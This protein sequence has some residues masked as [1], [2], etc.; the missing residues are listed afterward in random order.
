MI[1]I[2]AAGGE[3]VQRT[4]R[5]AMRDGIGGMKVREMLPEEGLGLR[6]ENC[7]IFHVLYDV[8]IVWI[9]F[10]TPQSGKVR[11]AIRRARRRRFEV[12]LAV[13]SARNAGC[14]L[15][16][17]LAAQRKGE[18]PNGGRDRDTLHERSSLTR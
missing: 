2:Y 1:R 17:P 9:E 8:E 7:L 4:A 11:L 14:G 18:N 3:N 5:E 12:R 6:A 15:I 16:E 10:R 13:L